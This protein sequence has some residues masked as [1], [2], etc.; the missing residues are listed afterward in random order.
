MGDKTCL[1]YF[2]RK[3]I[4]N[5]SV[6]SPKKRQKDDICKI[7]VWK[8]CCGKERVDYSCS[9]SCLVMVSVVLSIRVLILES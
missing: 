2:D 6:G 1:E 5:W 9:V 7:D 3:A 4:G 8:L